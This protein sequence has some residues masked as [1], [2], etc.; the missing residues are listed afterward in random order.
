MKLS[1][2]N[3]LLK[4]RISPP[5]AAVVSCNFFLYQIKHSF[6]FLAY[7]DDSMFLNARNDSV[8]TATDV[9]MGGGPVLVNPAAGGAS[10]PGGPASYSEPGG[11][12]KMTASGM[13][14]AARFQDGGKNKKA[15]SKMK[16]AI[17]GPATYYE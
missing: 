12:N 5:H 14:A 6:I 2:F 1:A 17:P 13:E 10:G 9:S 7:P 8:V 15:A 4:F 11:G 16:N 3:S